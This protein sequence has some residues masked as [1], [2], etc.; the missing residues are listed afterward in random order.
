MDVSINTKITFCKRKR[1]IIVQIECKGWEAIWATPE[2][3]MIFFSENVPEENTANY[4]CV[5]L[6]LIQMMGRMASTWGKVSAPGV[7]R[8]VY[9]NFVLFS[10]TL[11]A[12]SILISTT[13]LIKFVATWFHIHICRVISN[14]I[15]PSSAL[16]RQYA[17]LVKLHSPS[18]VFSV[19]RHVWAGT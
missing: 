9:N 12:W 14:P 19:R 13:I 7:R 18:E 2:S 16:G 5:S 3:F 10:F 4:L 6:C 17:P 11:I 15:Q 1:K 8:N